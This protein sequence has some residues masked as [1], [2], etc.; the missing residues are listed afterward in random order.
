MAEQ[1]YQIGDIV[2]GMEVTAVRYNEEN[3][4]KVNFEYSFQDPKD[5]VRPKENVEET[6][7]EEQE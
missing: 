5:V 1:K 6:T 7:E 2:D 4:E 3:G